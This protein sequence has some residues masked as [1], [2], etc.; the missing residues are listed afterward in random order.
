MPA[1]SS[2]LIKVILISA[3]MYGYYLVMLRNRKFHRYNRFYLLSSVLIPLVLPF[4]PFDSLFATSSKDIP[5]IIQ[6]YFV[7][8]AVVI[9][10]S[11]RF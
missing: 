9:N 6:K 3:V 1:L 11:S 2:Y 8:D 7:H 4:I 10:M 5:L